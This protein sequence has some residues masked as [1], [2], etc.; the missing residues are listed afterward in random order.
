MKFLKYIAAATIS[1]F[2]YAPTPVYACGPY[3]YE[4]PD[5]SFF[6][7]QNPDAVE[8]RMDENIR[9][10]QSQ[11]SSKVSLE[12]IREVIYGDTEPDAW[13]NRYS[14]LL[15]WEI[16]GY[17]E[18]TKNTFLNY[19]YNAGDDEAANCIMVAKHVARLRDD[20]NSPWYYPASKTD[21][22]TGFDPVIHTIEQY[23]GKRF[24]NRYSLQLIRA[25]FASAR[26]EECIAA[27]DSRFAGVADN[28]L[29][30]SMARDYA[31]GA[32]CRLGNKELATRYFASVG[33]VASLRRYVMSEDSAFDISV[34]LC[35]DSP[36]LM[37][38]IDR[39]IN[40]IE[41]MYIDSAF[42]RT[43]I[44][45]AA[46]SV[47]RGNKTS[48]RGLWHYIAAI[49]EGRFKDNDEAAYKHICVAG[50]VNRG[51][52]KD[53]IR[54]YKMMLEARMGKDGGLLADMK[55][56]ECKVADLTAPDHSYWV[57]VMQ[58]IVL[59]YLV[60]AYAEKGDVITAIQLANYGENMLLKYLPRSWRFSDSYWF[61]NDV[62]DARFDPSK[63]N[64]S[65]FSNTFFIFMQ[66]QSPETIERYVA[67]LSCDKPLYRFLN[68][69]CYTDRNYLLDLAG[70][71]YLR[72]RD[73]GNAVRVLS[74]VAPSYQKLLNVDREGY[75]RRN[76]FS[77]QSELQR[78]DWDEE[79]FCDSPGR[80]DTDNV[81]N[82][83]KLYFAKE[84]L[85][86][87]N[88][89][90]NCTDS[91][92]RG[93][94]R[95]KYAIGLEN[96]FNACWALT[97]YH[98]GNW[99]TKENEEFERFYEPENTQKFAIEKATKDAERMREQA[100]LEIT[101]PEVAARAHYQLYNYRTI[102]RRY[103]RTKIGRMM[104]A[105]CDSWSD[106][107]AHRR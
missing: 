32:A 39:K 79:Y 90:A 93:L 78:N 86:L 31:A 20:R 40:G 18:K 8:S 97:S 66:N 95:L 50:T 38:F 55:W 57:E 64:P 103:P 62:R 71:L 45:P 10:W 107:V 48:N 105:S 13:L 44:L 46:N 80:V 49:C 23:K 56:L 74:E 104:A 87:E 33:D 12:D 5:P 75:L 51:V 19:L 17:S 68:A 89:I 81:R 72:H 37:E 63:R 61:D 25:L 85:R 11:T 84:M 76:P 42:V 21:V 24:Y 2:A 73:Y 30:K 54:A 22:E 35:P 101:D 88:E 98:R 83:K 92:Q 65:D 36:K 16:S 47:L 102:A 29:M 96:S 77:Y 60:P 99:I 3:S 70:T 53:I 52:S 43:K 6:R 100:L 15:V 14:G 91:N 58:H 106:W 28:E 26:Y 69:G 94:A 1:I 67:S 27:F 4:V 59:G 34:R 7:L 41:Q 9:L 82:N